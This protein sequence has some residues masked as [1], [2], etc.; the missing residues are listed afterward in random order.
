MAQSSIPLEAQDYVVNK[1][2]A[3]DWVV[4]RCGVSQHGWGDGRS[5]VHPAPDLAGDH[6]EPWDQ[7]D[8]GIVTSTAHPPTGSVAFKAISL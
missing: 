3:L 6:G 1:K 8:R 4:E 7:Q 2:P 5:A